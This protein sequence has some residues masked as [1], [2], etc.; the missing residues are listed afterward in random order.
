MLLLWVFPM[1]TLLLIFLPKF[2]A[3]RNIVRGVDVSA[4]PV[5]GQRKARVVV[6]GIPAGTQSSNT[7]GNSHKQTTACSAVPESTV[8]EAKSEVSVAKKSTGINEAVQE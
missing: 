3:Y 4:Q 8:S 2:V 1:S 6:S 5:R 7:G